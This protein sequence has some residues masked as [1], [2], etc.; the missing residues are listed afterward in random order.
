MKLILR[1]ASRDRYVPRKIDFRKSGSSINPFK[2]CVERPFLRD[3]RER[4]ELFYRLSLIYV[5]PK[6]WTVCFERDRRPSRCVPGSPAKPVG[7]RVVGQSPTHGNYGRGFSS[8]K[9]NQRAVERAR[10]FP[11]LAL[12]RFAGDHPSPRPDLRTASLRKKYRRPPTDEFSRSAGRQ[13]IADRSVR[14]CPVQTLPHV[15]RAT[16][17]LATTCVRETFLGRTILAAFTVR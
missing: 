14:P 9:E 13:E 11:I 15:G 7:T 1:L 3:N 2:P 12:V 8:E 6:W 10:F 4:R 17:A 16:C 5:P